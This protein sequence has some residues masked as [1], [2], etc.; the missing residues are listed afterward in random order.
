MLSN[1]YTSISCSGSALMHSF[2]ATIDCY[3]D[4]YCEKGFNLD[5]HRF[6]S[7][8]LYVFLVLALFMHNIF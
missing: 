4:L 2:E 1:F 3:V 6:K 8:Y 7:S 5:I